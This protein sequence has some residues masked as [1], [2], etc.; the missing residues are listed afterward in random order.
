MRTKSEW[1]GR[2]AVNDVVLV[3]VVDGAEDLF[4]CLR[5]I[6]LGELSLVADTI[7]QLATSSELGDNVELVL[8][9]R[10]VSSVVVFLLTE[11]GLLLIQTSR[12][13]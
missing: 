5:G 13:T 9:A 6:L 10:A 11:I 2:T 8:Q 1:A 12:Q 3:Q 7:E 4:Y